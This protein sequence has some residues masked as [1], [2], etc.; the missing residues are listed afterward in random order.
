MDV[1][2]LINR[3]NTAAAA[4]GE[5]EGLAASA[6]TVTMAATASPSI[7]GFT[8][9]ATAAPVNVA[10]TSDSPLQTVPANPAAISAA[11]AP[12]SDESVH[13]HLASDRPELDAILSDE[14][15][16]DILDGWAKLETV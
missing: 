2:S 13:R 16:Q 7:G 9:S 4:A 11:A 12:S 5:G 10:L 8:S 1:L 6:G 14:L 3:L 15:A